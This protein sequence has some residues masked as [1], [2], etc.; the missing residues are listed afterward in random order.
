MLQTSRRYRERM[1]KQQWSRSEACQIQGQVESPILRRPLQMVKAGNRSVFHL[2]WRFGNS[3]GEDVV[4]EAVAQRP[5]RDGLANP[6]DCIS[7]LQSLIGSKVEL[8]LREL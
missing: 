5:P 1:A 3:I 2:G 8:Q 7:T 4:V 6:P